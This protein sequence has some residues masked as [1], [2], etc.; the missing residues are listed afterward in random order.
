MNWIPNDFALS[1]LLPTATAAILAISQMLMARRIKQRDIEMD[2]QKQLTAILEI[3]IKYPYLEDKNFT[4]SWNKWKESGTPDD[5]SY[6]LYLRYDQFANILFNYLETLYKAK[7]K[8]KKEIEK[9]LDVK[10]WVCLHRQIW[11][12]P[13]YEDENVNGYDDDFRTYI[14]SYLK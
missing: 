5:E 8:K 6:Q 1:D 12:N 14:N 11:E 3:T 9:E 7:N 2:L 10:S 4:R 13:R